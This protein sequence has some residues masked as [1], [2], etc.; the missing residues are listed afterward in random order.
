LE[1]RTFT[2]I[3]ILQP[4]VAAFMQTVSQGFLPLEGQAALFVEIAPG[5]AIN[6]V[7]DVALKTT[8]AIPG[9][10][11]IERAYGLLE[12]HHTE[13]GQVREAGR[14]ILEHLA[15]RESDRL[16]P[17]ILSEQIITGIAGYH[18][19]L[20]NRMR[21][22]DMILENQTLYTLEVHPAAYAAIAT[23][24]AEKRSPIHVL[25]FVSFGAFGRV[26][27]GGGEAE[28]NEAVAAIRVALNA[29]D[30]RPNTGAAG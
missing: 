5:I 6:R 11:I 27:L 7:T 21:H 10:Q 18:T 4:Q 2:F 1:L 29:I 22:G 12:L 16:K 30:G 15:L 25:E 13:Q 28:I 24:E 14:A 26:W 20:V 9:M 8:Q 17:R 3:D 19:Q 23:N